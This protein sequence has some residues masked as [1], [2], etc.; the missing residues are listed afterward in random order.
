MTDKEAALW[1]TLARFGLGLAKKVVTPANL[2]TRNR[3]ALNTAAKGIKSKFFTPTKIKGFSTG[4]KSGIKDPWYTPM[5]AAQRLTQSPIEHYKFLKQHGVK[6]WFGN[7]LMKTKYHVD[8]TTGD[9]FKRSI[10]GRIAAS[11]VGGGLVGATGFG[12]M[13]LASGSTPGQ[14][15]RTT[16]AWTFAPGA[17]G[18]Y[19]LGKLGFNLLKP[20]KKT[21]QQQQQ[22]GNYNNKYY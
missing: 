11:T 20:K 2:Y 8:S 12:A 3:S 5:G 9:V 19:E 1:G 17:A 6:K 14:A 22:F 15:L 7:E 4:V 13:D 21:Q 10:G 18:T 16:A